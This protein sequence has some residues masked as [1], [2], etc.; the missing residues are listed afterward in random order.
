M[1]T[2]RRAEIRFVKKSVMLPFPLVNVF[3]ILYHNV[4]WESIMVNQRKA[5]SFGVRCIHVNSVM[6]DQVAIPILTIYCPCSQRHWNLLHLMKPLYR[7]GKE[8]ARVGI[9]IHLGVILFSIYPPLL[10][11]VRTDYS[12]LAIVAVTYSVNP[13]LLC[14]VRT[15]YSGLAIVAVTFSINPPLL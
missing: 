10:C 12:G 14:S 2:P 4:G 3:T 5:N 15:D 7:N 13:P 9:I 11:S 1:A 8:I 6:G